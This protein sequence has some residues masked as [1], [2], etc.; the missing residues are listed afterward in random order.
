MVLSNSESKLAD[1][2]SSKRP[3]EIEVTRA[4]LMQAL[5]GKKQAEAI[6]AS[7]EAVLPANTLA[8]LFPLWPNA[9]RMCVG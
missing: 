8:S 7:D 3:Q 9:E 4:Q 1:L 2:R 6:L 5:A